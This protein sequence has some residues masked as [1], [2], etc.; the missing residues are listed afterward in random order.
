MATE[1]PA[2]LLRLGFKLIERAPG[3]M[4]A[5][6]TGWG[7]TGTKATI[8][9]VITEARAIAGYLQR[10]TSANERNGKGRAE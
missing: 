2:D 4:F 9:E 6:S 7:C 8:D 5:V 3:R 1:L 10:R